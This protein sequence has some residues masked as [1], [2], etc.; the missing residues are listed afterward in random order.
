MLGTNC[1][2]AFYSY[3]KPDM[4]YYHVVLCVNRDKIK[5]KYW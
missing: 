2:V 1:F 4:L 3:T 5:N